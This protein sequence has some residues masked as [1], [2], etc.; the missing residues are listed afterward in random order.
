VIVIDNRRVIPSHA[1]GG[2]A[3]QLGCLAAI[4]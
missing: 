3:S 1:I 2:E 4:W